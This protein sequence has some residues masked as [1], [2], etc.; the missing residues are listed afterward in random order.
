MA[1]AEVGKACKYVTPTG[2]VVDAVVTATWTPGC[3]NLVFASLDEE[4]KDTYG[5]QMEHDSSVIHAS[6][7]MRAQGWFFNDRATTEK[8]DQ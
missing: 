3:V 8:L 1:K 2:Q 4:R 6:N 7:P 5:R